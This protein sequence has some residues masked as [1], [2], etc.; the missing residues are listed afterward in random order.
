MNGK[1]IPI[2]ALERNRAWIKTV[3]DSLGK[4][5]DLE[6][7]KCT[8]RDTGRKSASQL[9]EK[10]IEHFKKKQKTVDEL[11]EAVN[12]RRRD[13]LKAK[14]FFVHEGSKIHFKLE[15]CSCDLVESG[16]AE[17]SPN[18]CLCSAGMLEGL[19]MPF[20]DGYV[21]TEI[22]KAIGLGD[23]YCEFIVYLNE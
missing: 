12:K 13:I 9:L 20:C 19:F 15:K 16:L 14:T 23:N 17:P 22:I 10:T 8:M 21:K 5:N 6:L 11:I 2:A 1:E 3:T 4:R 18:F 7:L